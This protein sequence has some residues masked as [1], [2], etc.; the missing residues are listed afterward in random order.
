MVQAGGVVTI[1]VMVCEVTC[2]SECKL[3]KMS[4]VCIEPIF[5]VSRNE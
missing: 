3:C 4:G 2:E 5:S 1:V